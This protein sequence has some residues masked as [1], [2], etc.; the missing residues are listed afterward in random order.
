MLYAKKEK[1]KKKGSAAF[2]LFGL[3]PLD[4]SGQRKLKWYCTVNVKWIWTQQ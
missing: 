2:A 4:E 3:S 1:E